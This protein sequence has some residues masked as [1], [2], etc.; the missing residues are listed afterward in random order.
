MM[1]NCLQ[2]D[3]QRNSHTLI[4]M[5][6][7]LAKTYPLVHPMHRQFYGICTSTVPGLPDAA[8]RTKKVSVEQFDDDETETEDGR[9][10]VGCEVVNL[11]NAATGCD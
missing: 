8:L 2:F 1:C 10:H 7:P 9:Q 11:I 6:N 3:G 5:L 4:R